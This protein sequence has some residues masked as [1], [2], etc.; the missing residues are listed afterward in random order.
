MGSMGGRDL[1]KVPSTSHARQRM[2][3]IERARLGSRLRQQKHAG[4]QQLLASAA[5]HTCEPDIKSLASVPSLNFN[6][7]L[8]PK[9]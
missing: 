4:P 8:N 3:F 7:H 1:R 9:P 2:F 5:D 6:P